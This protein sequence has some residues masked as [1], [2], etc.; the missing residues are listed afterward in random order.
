MLILTRMSKKNRISQDVSLDYR[1]SALY[2][3]LED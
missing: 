1:I 3:E 2:N